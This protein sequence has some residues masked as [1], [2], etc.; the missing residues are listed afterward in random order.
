MSAAT[1]LATIRAF[2][3]NQ[4]WNRC[5]RTRVPRGLFKSRTR[6]LWAER[7]SPWAPLRRFPY[8]RAMCSLYITSSEKCLIGAVSL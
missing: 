4:P 6:E 3:L 5:T 2:A 8:L 1:H 7:G